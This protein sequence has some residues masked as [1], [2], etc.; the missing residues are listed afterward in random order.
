M[1]ILERAV[2]ADAPGVIEIEYSPIKLIALFGGG[3]L[4]TG[5]AVLV[6]ILPLPD[7]P[8]AVIRGVGYFGTIFFGYCTIVIGWD[9]LTRRGPVVTITSHGIR[10]TRIAAEFIPWTA[11]RRISTGD[12]QVVLSIDP[13]L[14]KQLTLTSTARLWRAPNRLLGVDG[15]WITAQC[16]KIGHSTLLSLCQ[17]RA[18]AAQSGIPTGA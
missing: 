13:A 12:K 3:V 4:M 18:W 17:S 15:L 9:L 11:V 2:P 16:L 8:G 1:K 7:V 6:A 5:A 10:D 14:E